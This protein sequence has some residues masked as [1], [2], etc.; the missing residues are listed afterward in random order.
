MASVRAGPVGQSQHAL[1]AKFAKYPGDLREQR[2]TRGTASESRTAK[3]RKN[4]R[5]SKNSRSLLERPGRRR[6]AATALDDPTSS[7]NL[8]ICQR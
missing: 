1:H 4:F 7:T 3:R 6:T 2:K 8:E 5:K